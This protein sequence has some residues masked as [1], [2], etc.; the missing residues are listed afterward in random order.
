MA[1]ARRGPTGARRRRRR[2][3]TARNASGAS[4]SSAGW[5]P[6]PRCDDRA[7]RARG[8]RAERP[9]T[10]RD[11]RTSQR[12]DEGATTE[13]LA[14]RAPQCAPDDHTLLIGKRR[15]EAGKVGSKSLWVTCR[16]TS[17]PRA[18]RSSGSAG[19]LLRRSAESRSTPR[20]AHGPIPWRCQPPTRRLLRD[21]LAPVK[22]PRLRCPS[23]RPL[24][25]RTS[26]QLLVLDARLRKQPQREL[27]QPPAA[28]S[29]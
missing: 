1:R 24:G 17:H 23:R 14:Q 2:G 8:N 9:L 15:D 25:D 6:I 11:A 27:R 20:P 19:R 7:I 29:G 5:R 16:P 10:A 21:L 22:Q 18:G 28:E 26:R 12:C 3:R 4:A 13:V